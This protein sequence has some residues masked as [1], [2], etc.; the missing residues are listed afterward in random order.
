MMSGATTRESDTDL[1][2]TFGIVSGSS[3]ASIHLAAICRALTQALG[4]P[5]TA[6]V[7]D[8]YAALQDEVAAGRAQIAWAPPLVAMDLEDA[9]LVSIDLCC[10]RGGEAGY[11]AALFTS[12][13]SRIET[14]RDLKG[15]HAAWVDAHSSAGYILPRLAIVAEGLDPK[16]LFGRESFL[17]SHAR[18]ARA[19]LEGEADV[20]ATYVS[21]DP[22]TGRPLSAGW[23]DAGAGI[24]SAFLLATAGPIPSDAIVLSRR[25]P[26]D[27]KAALVAQVTALP[28]AVL[29]EV[30]RLLGADGFAPAPAS[31][32]ATMRRLLGR[33]PESA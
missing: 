15:A 4:R 3:S 11:H 20:G 25:L 24:N 1:P 32:F 29:H 8:S 12:H 16:T 14:L 23:L 18:V 13:A 26:A 2:L 19:V 7:L 21:L 28:K 33:K 5:V 6:R 17:G 9:G 10:T 31:H 22:K 27:L 30:G